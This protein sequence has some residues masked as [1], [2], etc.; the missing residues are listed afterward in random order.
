M[1][2]LKCYYGYW[3]KIKKMDEEDI[4]EIIKELK[5]EEE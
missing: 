2:E 3:E 1:Q 5:L 4:D